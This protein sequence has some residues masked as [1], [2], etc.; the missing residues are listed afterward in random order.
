MEECKKGQFDAF[1]FTGSGLKIC[2]DFDILS[3]APLKSSPGSYAVL[4]KRAFESLGAQVAL[5]EDFECSGIATKRDSDS[6]QKL[7]QEVDHGSNVSLSLLG[8][9]FKATQC[10]TPEK[11]TKKRGNVI[12][13]NVKGITPRT[14]KIKTRQCFINGSIQP[15]DYNKIYFAGDVIPASL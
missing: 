10:W 1:Q 2:S 15:D 13:L 14:I 4:H 3:A 5:N 9:S 6:L 8:D 12:L 11:R 7:I